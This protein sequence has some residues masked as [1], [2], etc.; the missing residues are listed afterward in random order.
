MVMR[1]HRTRKA[2]LVALIAVFGLLGTSLLAYAASG[3]GPSAAAYPTQQAKVKAKGTLQAPACT[4]PTKG[5]PKCGSFSA[6]LKR[7]ATGK[8]AGEIKGSYKVK[9]ALTKT[10]YSFKEFTSLTCTD[11]ASA[12]LAST[13]GK[14]SG[15]ANKGKTYSQTTTLTET[16]ATTG[17]LNTTIT[18]NADGVVFTYNGSLDKAKFDLDCP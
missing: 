3:D 5:K 10:T 1:L 8:H 2:S 16:S 17:V 11:Q 15:K 6:S 9:D 7:D 12:Q 18:D 13:T 14:A 4:T